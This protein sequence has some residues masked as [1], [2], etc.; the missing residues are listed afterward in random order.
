MNHL[1]VFQYFIFIESVVFSKLGNIFF[2][3]INPFVHF[4]NF[5]KVFY[6]NLQI[7]SL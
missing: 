1:I 3:Y 2:Q 5:M 4:L 6:F 7:L